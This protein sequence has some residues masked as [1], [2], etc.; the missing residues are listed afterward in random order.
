MTT[1]THEKA[2]ADKKSR[3]K[4]RAT[5]DA[6]PVDCPMCGEGATADLAP[7]P[8]P[9]PGGPHPPPMPPPEGMNVPEVEAAEP[10]RWFLVVC[11]DPDTGIPRHRTLWPESRLGELHDIAPGRAQPEVHSGPSAVTSPQV[12][13]KK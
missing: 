2:H 1:A 3:A 6:T 5:K 13:T 11:T 12:H 9:T 10:G 4:D 7:N 8:G